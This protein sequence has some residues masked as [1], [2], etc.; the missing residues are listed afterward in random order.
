VSLCDQ[1]GPSV[2]WFGRFSPKEKIRASGL[3]LV[4]ELGKVPLRTDDLSRLA[5]MVV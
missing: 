4:N 3:W 2:D 5:T 1:C